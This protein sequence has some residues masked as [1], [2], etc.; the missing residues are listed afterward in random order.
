MPKVVLTKTLP[1]YYLGALRRTVHAGEEVYVSEQGLRAALRFDPDA[2]VTVRED[3]DCGCGDKADAPQE[4]PLSAST[5][6]RTVTIE[7]AENDALDVTESFQEEEETP[8]AVRI[9]ESSWYEL[10]T[11]EKIQGKGNIPDQYKP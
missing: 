11:G 10:P 5:T 3:E 1:G 4:S 6:E 9:G 7:E 8:K 2:T